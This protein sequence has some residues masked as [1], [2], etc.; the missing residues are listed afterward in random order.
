MQT[1]GRRGGGAWFSGGDNLI[2]GQHD[3]G[4]SP[5]CFGPTLHGGGKERVAEPE[6]G[7]HE[8]VGGRGVH[9]PAQHLQ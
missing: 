4:V 2:Q 1:A 7:R 3:A 6:G 8:G 9:S 5:V